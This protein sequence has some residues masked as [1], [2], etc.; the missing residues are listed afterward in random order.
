MPNIYQKH[1]YITEMRKALGLVAQGV[2]LF[3]NLCKRQVI[4]NAIS[5]EDFT[6]LNYGITSEELSEA[7]EALGQV[8][9][10]MSAENSQKI[11][12]VI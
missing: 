11:F 9:T 4:L 8:L 5:D 10:E 12:K 6:D 7:V 1:S 2:A 3:E